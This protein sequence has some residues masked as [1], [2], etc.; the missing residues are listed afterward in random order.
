MLVS[1][2]SLIRS[3]LLSL[4]AILFVCN[5]PVHFFHMTTTKSFISKPSFWYTTLI[6]LYVLWFNFILGLI[7]IFLCFKAWSCMIMSLKQR[8][9]KIKTRIK[10]NHNIYI[11]T[12]KSFRPI[13]L[14]DSL[15]AKSK[16]ES[17]LC[18]KETLSFSFSVT[19]YNFL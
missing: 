14:H 1:A 16:F 18:T 9:I 15:L 2:H 4:N 7:F 10:L 11:K 8:E 3:D 12:W 5:F 6:T 13:P 17:L 19:L